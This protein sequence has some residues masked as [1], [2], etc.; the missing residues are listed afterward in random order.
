MRRGRKR[1]AGMQGS[2]DMGKLS[3]TKKGASGKPVV[4]EKG[5]THSGS[6]REEG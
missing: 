5:G 3:V 4:T 1:R 2:K 6:F